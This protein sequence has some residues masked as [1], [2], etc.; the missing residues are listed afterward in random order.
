M[1]LLV[2][3]DGCMYV[4]KSRFIRAISLPVRHTWDF[5]IGEVVSCVSKKCDS[6]YR[7]AQGL[8]RVA[9]VTY[10][11]QPTSS[12]ELAI[13][14]HAIFEVP[15]WSLCPLHVRAKTVLFHQLFVALCSP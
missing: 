7:H 5:V 11:C 12:T 13:V 14:H 3:F 9:L 4:I 10:E 15:L 8:C 6:S 2:E 1:I